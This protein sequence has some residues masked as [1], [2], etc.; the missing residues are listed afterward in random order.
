M[1]WLFVLKQTWYLCLKG[2]DVL[3][4]HFFFHLLFFS[5]LSHPL[6]PL[7]HS[8]NIAFI[9]LKHPFKRLFNIRFT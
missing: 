2:C 6:Q 3:T 7:A 1:L 8:L 5:S 4:T 9:Q